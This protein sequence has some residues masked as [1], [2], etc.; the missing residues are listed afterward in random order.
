MIC[1]EGK[2]QQQNNMTGFT[3]FVSIY[4]FMSSLSEF[5]FSSA[6]SW[7]VHDLSSGPFHFNNKFLCLWN[8]KKGSPHDSLMFPVGHIFQTIADTNNC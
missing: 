6:A 2:Q 5:P 7:I 1:K 3:I 4:L 8:G